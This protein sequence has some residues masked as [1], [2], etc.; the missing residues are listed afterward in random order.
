DHSWNRMLAQRH[1]H[2]IHRPESVLILDGLRYPYYLNWRAG[3]AIEAD[4]LAHRIGTRPKVFRELLIHYGDT[5]RIRGIGRQEAA[6]TQNRN[7]RRLEVHLINGLH[8]RVEIL[9]IARHLE[10]VRHESHA[11]KSILSK[12][13]IL[14]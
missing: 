8:G 13:N 14:G 4:V 2:K 1:I 11:V 9:A 7:A 6:A 10:P 5:R 3:A 12:R